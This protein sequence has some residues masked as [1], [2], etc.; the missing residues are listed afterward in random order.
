MH[1]WLAEAM[2]RSK[3]ILLILLACF[4]LSTIMTRAVNADGCTPSPSTGICITTDKTTYSRRGRHRHRWG[5][6]VSQ[7]SKRNGLNRNLFFAA[8]VLW[9]LWC[10]MGNCH[11]ASQHYFRSLDRNGR[12]VA[13]YLVGKQ[14]SSGRQL[15]GRGIRQSS[16]IRLSVCRRCNYSHRPDTRARITIRSRVTTSCVA[17]R[18]IRFKK[19]EKPLDWFSYGYSSA[20]VTAA[21]VESP[22]GW[23]K[24]TF[25]QSQPSLNTSHYRWPIDGILANSNND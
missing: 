8:T 21:I 11:S 13:S 18:D 20:A 2:S 23:R 6:C 12:N 10:Y 9:S 4:M 3:G 7:Y 24:E 5:N 17:G 15:Y 19:K 14:Q 22:D 1:C 25:H 16:P